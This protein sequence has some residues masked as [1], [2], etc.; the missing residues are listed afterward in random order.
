MAVVE[1]IATTYLEDDAASITFSSIPQTY[2]NLQLRCSIHYTSLNAYNEVFIQL[3]TGGTVDTGT[4]Y[5]VQGMRGENTYTWER[6]TEGDNEIY[7]Q[8]G[9]ASTSGGANYSLMVTDLFNYA[10]TTK[11][12]PTLST[13]SF[14]GPSAGYFY[15]TMYGGAWDNTGAVS[16]IKISAD[17]G[18]VGR[19]TV[20][21]LYGWNNS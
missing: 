7:V 2:E 11:T 5:A 16:D 17:S 18:N 8:Y 15:S 19:G 12:K 1:A 10:S 3:G 21:T 6:Q 9:A 20:V 13:L 14:H 4:N